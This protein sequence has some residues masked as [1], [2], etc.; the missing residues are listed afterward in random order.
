M[1]KA[2]AL[3]LGDS[4][5]LW[6]REAVKAALADTSASARVC[7]ATVA[8][9]YNLTREATTQE[10]AMD[11]AK[12]VLDAI[13]KAGLKGAG[14]DS[15]IRRVF[16]ACHADLVAVWDTLESTQWVSF[17]QM[18]RRPDTGP[19]FPASETKGGRPA[20]KGAGKSTKPKAE[21]KPID[22][23]LD[24]EQMILLNRM[25]ANA[26]ALQYRPHKGAAYEP[27]PAAI[28]A[29]YR[30]HLGRAHDALQR[31]LDSA[32]MPKATTL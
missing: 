22:L 8:L 15:N 18:F 11:A 10:A 32:E 23:R 16:R 12:P 9:A 2:T 25:Q 31:L 24:R 17:Q 7:R 21:E 29:E 14:Y 13:H 1:R 5:D 6:I 27:A 28:T 19:A 30:L 4:T 3:S 20:G 26:A